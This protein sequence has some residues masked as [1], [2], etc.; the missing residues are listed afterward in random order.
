MN[1]SK[2]EYC[3]LE[4]LDNDKDV[5]DAVENNYGGSTY[6]CD[7]MAEVSDSFVDIYYSDIWKNSRH[8]DDYIDS[9]L[10]DGLCEGVNDI[11]KIMQI[12]QCEYYRTLLNNNEEE[13][14]FNIA[15]NY[16]NGIK[17]KEEV[18]GLLTEEDIE[19]SLEELD[20]SYEIEDIYGAIDSLIEDKINELEEGE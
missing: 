4:C 11:Y 5:L 12:G 19:N 8:I 6:L 18:I 7:A 13:I 1:I 10:E 2:K 15:I 16:L 3:L 17:D 9:A 20:A 14:M